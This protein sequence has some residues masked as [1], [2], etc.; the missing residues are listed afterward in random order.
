MQD[1]TN[2]VNLQFLGKGTVV[3]TVK[4]ADGNIAQGVTVYIATSTTPN[5]VYGGTTDTNGQFTFNNVPTGSFSVRA[6]YPGQ[7]FYSTTT[8]SM[9]GNG[10]TVQLAASLTPVGTISGTLTYPNGTPVAQ[11]YVYAKD[12]QSIYSSYAQTD[13]AGNYAL[14]PVPADRTVNLTSSYYDNTLNK[15]LS[16]QALNQQ[17]PGDGQTLTVNLR[18]PGAATVKVTV[19]KSDGTP[20]SSGYVNL[21]SKD[22]SQTYSGSIGSD[23]TSTFTSVLEG[24]FVAYANINSAFNA[25]SKIFTVAP[26]NDGTTVNVTI[27][28]SLTGTVQG[29]VFAADG[30]TVIRDG[31][32]VKIT[33]IDANTTNEADP[34]GGQG[35]N[36]TNVQVGASGFNL[37]AALNANSTIAQSATG[38][39]TSSGQI[40]TQNFTLPISSISGTV[41]L[42]DGVTPVPNA[43][44]SVIQTISG[45]SMYYQTTSDSNGT[46]QISG[47]VTG[48]VTVQASD[49]NGVVGVT[50]VT[51]PSD[52]S[53]V[54]GVKINLGATGTVVGVAYSSTSQLLANVNVNIQSSGNNGGFSTYVP[55]D[56]NGNFSA[57]DIPV[58]NITVSTYENSSSQELSATGV[59]NNNGDT[60]TIDVGNVPPPRTNEV[61]GTVYDANQNPAPGAAV[62]VT[63]ADQ[64]I[65]PQT[66]T[67]DSNGLYSVGSLPIGSVTVSA[68]LADGTQAGSTTGAITNPQTPVE[69]DVGLQNP[70]VVSGVVLDSSGNPVPNAKINCASS[71]DTSSSEGEGTQSDGSFYFPG[72]EPGLV[73]LTV[74]DDN[75]NVLG[76]ANGTL[77]YGGNLTLNVKFQATASSVTQPAFS[78]PA[79]LGLQ[80]E[81]SYVN[82]PQA[83]S[84]FVQLH[85]GGR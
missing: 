2:T 75:G 70:G 58:G 55:T 38:N 78:R 5:Y 29:Q 24:T 8:G 33:D 67:T 22:G 32:N 31:Y 10:N 69:I 83:G 59:L 60:V 63:P 3:T 19:L 13:S 23:G 53:I 34:S 50:P 79:A 68:V 44:I 11:Q 81:S 25:G 20:Y 9:T 72:I 6:Y 41:F 56:A 27:N 82:L 39:I 7:G 62:T 12:A 43:N 71:G 18:F 28:T 26:A 45:S 77:P 47:P 85:A 76:T 16:T 74:T 14:T 51:L 84:A 61:F 30:T 37:T 1:A 64:T 17:V 57:T 73:T 46:Y 52:T 15:N 36:F 80:A 66:S 54:T 35:Y 4:Y 42:Y 40:I 49:S 65:Q 21:H 48:T